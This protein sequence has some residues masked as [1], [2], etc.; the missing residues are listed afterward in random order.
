MITLKRSFSC[1]HFYRQDQWSNEKNRTV[2]GKCFTDYGHG[3]DYLLEVTFASGDEKSL[4]KILDP[5]V[6]GLDHR[7][8]NF[9][10]PEFKTKVPTTENLALYIQDQ[11]N[12]SAKIESLK[13]FERPD[14]W[15]ELSKSTSS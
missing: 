4:S 15:V 6:E 13:L 12:R 3:H 5:I 1:A 8:L 7:H 9:V 11:I 2:F 10:I 14:L